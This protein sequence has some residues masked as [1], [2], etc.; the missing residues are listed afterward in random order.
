MAVPSFAVLKQMRYD[1]FCERGEIVGFAIK[2]F[3]QKVLSR[4][5]IRSEKGIAVFTRTAIPFY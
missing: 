1:G 3:R 2:M 4:T 5:P